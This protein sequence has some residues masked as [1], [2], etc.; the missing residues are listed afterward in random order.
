MKKKYILHLDDSI[1]FI[2]SI[3]HIFEEIDVRYRYKYK[4]SDIKELLRKELPDLFI[5][6]LM[7]ENE[8]NADPGVNLV[9]F[10][11]K[12]YPDLKIMILS[13]RCDKSIQDELE[14]YIVYYETK[15]Y[16]PSVFQNKIIELL[17]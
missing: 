5:A 10:L 11:H 12:K 6:D 7:L 1:D 16:R 13:A 8:H 4:A 17:R 15:S 9:K 14:P 3:K 2:N